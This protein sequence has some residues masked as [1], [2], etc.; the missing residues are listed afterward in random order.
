MTKVAG[1]EQGRQVPRIGPNESH[2]CPK[3]VGRVLRTK[4]MQ[5]YIKTSVW[6]LALGSLPCPAITTKLS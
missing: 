2:G 5:K 6:G 4:I 3:P 1:L